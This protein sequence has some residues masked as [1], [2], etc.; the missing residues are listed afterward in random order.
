MPSTPI[1]GTREE[2][3]KSI[4][5]DLVAIT[6][7]NGYA[8]T[9]NQVIRQY[10]G[11]PDYKQYNLLIESGSEST[12][13]WLLQDL[14]K[15]TFT[16]SIVGICVDETYTGAQRNVVTTTEAFLREV[17][18]ALKAN[19]YRTLSGTAKAYLSLISNVTTEYMASQGFFVV[20]LT[21]T[22]FDTQ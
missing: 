20:A 13:E 7:A 2:I 22:Y 12:E 3:L 16:V 21:T 10:E 1:L 6:T 14:V 8:I 5:N 15:K 11:L 9:V 18:K 4:Y 19:P 17:E